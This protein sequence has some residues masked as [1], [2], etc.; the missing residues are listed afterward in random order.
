MILFNGKGDVLELFRHM[1]NRKEL[2]RTG[3][4]HAFIDETV[5]M[6]NRILVESF[7]VAG[8][9]IIFIALN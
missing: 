2:S 5:E 7:E 3:K 9:T 1:K 6:Q 4:C 8:K